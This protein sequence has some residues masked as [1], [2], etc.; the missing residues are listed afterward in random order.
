MT[1][2]ELPLSLPG[3]EVDE[4]VERDGL[5]RITPTRYLETRAQSNAKPI[6]VSQV[7]DKAPLPMARQLA[8]LYVRP[9]QIRFAAPAL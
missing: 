8:W 9:S 2:I 6:A 3:F 7:P 5:V 4:V 1:P